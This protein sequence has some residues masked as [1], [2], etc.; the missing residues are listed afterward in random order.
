M[1]A[2]NVTVFKPTVH[3]LGTEKRNMFLAP[4][5]FDL[6]EDKLELG[7]H[8]LKLDGEEKLRIRPRRHL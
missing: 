4:R 7:Y 8:E 3:D 6:K 2:Y 1:T 5:K